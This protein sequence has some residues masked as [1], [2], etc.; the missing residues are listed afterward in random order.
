MRR[1]HHLVGFLSSKATLLMSRARMSPE[2]ALGALCGKRDGLGEELWKSI[3]YFLWAQSCDR[4]IT[5]WSF[6]PSHEAVA[7]QEE[8]VGLQQVE[9]FSHLVSTWSLA[10]IEVK[11][12]HGIA[13]SSKGPGLLLTWYSGKTPRNNVLQWGAHA[14]QAQLWIS[15]FKGILEVGMGRICSWSLG[16]LLSFRVG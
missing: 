13:H 9:F 3:A 11:C 5:L 7:S 15:L 12:P 1:S 6:E 2:W 10:Y 14:F 8:W 16:E 4:Y